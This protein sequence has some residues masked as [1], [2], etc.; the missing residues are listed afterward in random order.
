[1][2]KVGDPRTEKWRCTGARH[3]KETVVQRSH[4]T[5]PR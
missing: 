4:H 2:M 5:W 3:I 1:M